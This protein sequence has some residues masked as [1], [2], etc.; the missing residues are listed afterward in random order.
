MCLFFVRKI[1]IGKQK[2]Q[3]LFWD[4]SMYKNYG[5]D[6]QFVIIAS[7]NNQLHTAQ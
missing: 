3:Y 7:Q 6:V 4:K 1:T 2:V 5:Y